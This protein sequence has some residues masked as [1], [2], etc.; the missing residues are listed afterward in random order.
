[1]ANSITV[2]EQNVEP[3]W[4]LTRNLNGQSSID[5][6]IAHALF[7]LGFHIHGAID[8]LIQHGKEIP[9]GFLEEDTV[10]IFMAILDDDA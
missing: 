1:V 9:V 4:R 7:S 2:D 8:G 5:R 10:E 6:N 3:E